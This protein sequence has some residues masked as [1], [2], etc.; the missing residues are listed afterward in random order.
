MTNFNIDSD[1]PAHV[2]AAAKARKE[3]KAEVVYD[4]FCFICTRATDHTG[5]HDN[6]FTEVEYTEL[7]DDLF[8]CS[9]FTYAK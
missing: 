1:V 2:V 4:Y 5:E 8:E 7:S 6:G 9:V 3:Q